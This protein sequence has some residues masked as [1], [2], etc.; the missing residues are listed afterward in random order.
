M[1]EGCPAPER[2]TTTLESPMNLSRLLSAL[3]PIGT[4]VWV[5]A[6]LGEI[7]GHLPELIRE[8]DGLEGL[9]GAAKRRAV[10][11]LVRE[12]LDELDSTPGWRLLDEGARDRILDGVAEIAFQI[13]RSAGTEKS[14]ELEQPFGLNWR[15]TF[16]AIRKRK[17]ELRR[18]AEDL[19]E[20]DEE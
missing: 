8:A 6:L 10:V 20:E 3:A 15:E 7:F 18:D 11:L 14:S 2:A 4:P 9:R 17:Q 13:T 16:R 19:T 1:L 5:L 12:A